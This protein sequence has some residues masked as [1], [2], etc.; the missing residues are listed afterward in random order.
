MQRLKDILFRRV[1]NSN[2]VAYRILFGLLMTCQCVTDIMSGRVKY[3]FIDPKFTVTFIGFGFLQPLAGN[4]MYYY[5]M[6]MAALGL[7]IAGGLYYRMASI[8][9][10]LMW[11]AIYFMQKTSYNNHYYLI[12]LLAGMMALIPAERSYSLDVI[13]RPEIKNDDCAQWIPWLFAAQ[14][15]IVY[16]FAGINKIYPDWISGRYLGLSFADKVGK[17]Y[18]G[19]I[20]SLPYTKY[21]VAYGGILFDVAIGPL[22]LWKPTRKW[23]FVAMC[24]FHGF[25]AI[26]FKIGIFP[27]LAVA[28][29]IF[30]FPAE[31]I[32]ELFF[33]KKLP[34]TG[35]SAATQ[36]RPARERMVMAV[37]GAYVL[38]QLLLP[39]RAYCY[40][41]KPNWTEAGHRLSWRMMLRTKEGYLKYRIIDTT[42]E[43]WSVDPATLLTP[44]QLHKVAVCPDMIWQV[45]QR[46]KQDYAAEGRTGV[47][48]Y[49]ISK[50]SLNGRKYKPLADPATD[51]AHTRWNWLGVN[52][53]ITQEPGD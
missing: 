15:C 18:T 51:L 37:G 28:T 6:V 24:L 53:W 44:R 36:T 19:F 34:Y 2:V 20:Y 17:P 9:F 12:T 50:A 42:G 43:Q 52:K 29:A 5:Y 46:L 3:E 48:I 26:T 16:F 10:T 41:G 13:R 39:L 31:V 22:M 1:D 33:P 27:Y 32:R 21:M 7:L 35:G 8:A 38:I 49:A 14:M 45:A 4:G 40:P 11:A 47:K 23:A 30:F 25:N